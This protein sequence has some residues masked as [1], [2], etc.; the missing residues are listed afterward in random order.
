MIDRLA[1]LPTPGACAPQGGLRGW[2][3]G[4]DASPLP[5]RA[6]EA[7]SIEQLPV[8]GRFVPEE[9]W[10]NRERFFYEGM[11]LVIGACF[12]DYG[13]PA[14]HR[15]AT[16]KFAGQPRLAKDGGL[17]DYRAGRP[18]PEDAIDPADP[19]AAMKWAWNLEHRYQA[20]GMFGPFR[21]S[22]MVGRT[23]RAE[24]FIG[25]IFKAQ[26]AFRADRA[27]DDYRAPG[28]RGKHWVAGGIFFKPFDARHFAWRQY[29]DLDHMTSAGRSDDLHA[30]LP[31][32]RRVRRLSANDVEG[33][34]MP[35]F[36]VGVVKSQT[37]AVA[38]VAAGGGAAAGSVGAGGTI[39]TKRSGFEGLEIRPLLYEYRLLGVR[40][41]LT[42]INATTPSYP[43]DEER[44]FGLW[45]LSFAS[46][47]WD[48][49]RAVVI[50]GA[51][52]RTRG[53]DAIARVRLHVDVQTGQ[54]LYYVSYDPKGEL[55]DVG[56]YVGRWSESREDYRRW[57]DR[58]ELPVRVIDTVGASFAHMHG[59]GGWRRESWTMVSTPPDDK[60][61]KRQLSVSN[62]TRRR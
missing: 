26:L 54:P 41:V 50:E 36:S 52:H 35:S 2:P 19:D 11:R 1:L 18:F 55:I 51:A 29:R 7:L 21:T 5:F 37:L 20:A 6:G 25:K 39:T 58:P 24:P 62:L 22:D 12:A 40:D 43:Q 34:Y 47:T 44:D 10:A 27:E 45:G 16:E 8:I 48:L 9:I 28:A 57:P 17:E 53:V 59:G 13:P 60:T 15:E 31:D 42:P 4:E 56:M 3:P 14:F 38:D 32:Y 33:L 46:D 30:Y 61:L 23:G 49:R